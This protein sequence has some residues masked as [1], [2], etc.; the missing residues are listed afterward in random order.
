MEIK[1]LDEISFPTNPS[2]FERVKPINTYR[3]ICQIQHQL[4][5]LKNMVNDLDKNLNS[6]KESFLKGE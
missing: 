6:L 3:K 1:K 2:E 4:E 5:T